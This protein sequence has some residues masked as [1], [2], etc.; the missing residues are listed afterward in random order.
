VA[1]GLIESLDQIP[2]MTAYLQRTANKLREQAA[3]IVALSPS[4]PDCRRAA[5]EVE[6]AAGACDETAQLAS[7]APPKA[8]AWAEQMV[9]GSRPPGPPSRDPLQQ[10]PPIETHDVTRP[11]Q[12]EGNHDGPV[13]GIVLRLSTS[14][15][16]HRSQLNKPPAESIIVVDN[17]FAYHTDQEGRVVRASATLR[18]VDIAHPRDRYAQRALSG[19]LPGDRAGHLFARIF[20]GPGQ[21]LNLTPMSGSG[22]NRGEYQTLEAE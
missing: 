17:Q 8:R 16:A 11:P 14:N 9:N 21:Q 3:H 13:D 2:M 22:V 7:L 6:A 12:S 19:K 5:L 4:N 15:R 20:Q 1:Q 10:V 18:T